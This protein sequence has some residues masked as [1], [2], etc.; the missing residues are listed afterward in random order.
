MAISKPYGEWS[1][2]ISA[3]RVAQGARPLSVVR[4]AGGKIHWLEGRAS[5]GGRNTLVCL[6]QGQVKELTANPW[7]VRTRVHEYG[8]G[9]YLVTPELLVFSHFQN[10]SLMLQKPGQEVL[11]LGNQPHQRFADCIH[12]AGRAR[13]IGVREE[14][15]ADGSE[16]VNTLCALA[17][18][19]SGVQTVLA[20]GHDFYSSPR[21]SP[22]GRQLA[23]LSWDHPRMPWQGTQLWLAEI[24][25]GGQLQNLRCVAGSESESICQ[26]E[27]SPGGDLVFASDRS[28]WWNLYKLAENG[29][30]LALHPKAAE[31]ASPHWVFGE[32]MYGFLRSGEIVCS[33]IEEG[34]SKLAVLSPGAQADAAWNLREIATPYSD[35]HELVVAEDRLVMLAASPTLPV[36]VVEVQIKGAEAGSCRVLATSIEELPATGYLSVPRSICFPSNGRKAYGFFYPPKN[37]D[38]SAEEGSKPPLVIFIHGGPTSMAGNGLR[39]GIQF[40]TSRGFAVLDVNYGGSSGFGR[41]FRDL[42]AG[43]WGVVDVEDCVNGARYLAEQGLADADKL[44]IRGG[45]AGGFTT[46]S[47]LIFHDVFKAGCSLFGVSDLAALDEDSHKFESQYNAYLVGPRAQVQE[48]YRARS[49][50]HH[51]DKLNKPMIFL[52]GLDDKVVPPPQSQLMVQALRTRGVPVAY[53]EFEGEGHGFRKAE[54]IQRSWEA[55]LYFYAKVFGFELADPVTPVQIDNL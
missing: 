30:S 38:Y 54:N 46:L 11:A 7:N 47:A 9:A 19:G 10:N 35:I 22:D 37:V 33:F 18:D 44:V 36:Q 6:D 45:S 20:Q 49:P 21:L 39:L 32:W 12:D 27:F 2:P 16:A 23:F 13:L 26:P 53:I 41:E 14:H 29:S 31:F 40:W 1:S 4:I 48:I 24:D 5:E 28:G 43:Q 25:G 15:P 3:A 42:L 55:E 8:G 17:L 34:D 50:I 52:Q 51:V